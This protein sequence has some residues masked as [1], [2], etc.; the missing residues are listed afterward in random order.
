MM[1]D[2]LLD[3]SIFALVES[4]FRNY[5]QINGESIPICRQPQG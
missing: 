4:G 1:I 2:L 3:T 5:H